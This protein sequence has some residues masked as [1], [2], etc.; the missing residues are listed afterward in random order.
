MRIIRGLGSYPPDARPSVVAL[1]VF[2]GVH[3]AHQ[4]ILDLA[5]ARARE[6]ALSAVACTFDPL[7]L[8]VLRPEQAP[9]P[10]VTLDERLELIAAR[11]VDLTVVIPF[12]REFSRV[13]P[14]AFVADVLL[15]TLRAREVVVG[16]NHT[17]GRGARGNAS[18]LG[19][20][21]ARLGFGLH[22]LPPL[23]VDGS[24]VSSSAVREALR[25]GDVAAARRLLGRPWAL[26]GV[27]VRGAGRGRRLGF[28][29]ANV[30]PD[31]PLPL[32]TGVY[33]GYTRVGPFAGEPG[34]GGAA[35][36]YKTV[37]NVGYRPTFEEGEYWVEAYL[38]D[39]SGDLYDRP[40][41]VSLIERVRE[42]RKF[43]DVS[44]LVTQISADVE[45]AGGIL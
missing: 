36:P 5:T 17:F 21:A 27:V 39:F 41:S 3:L 29:T 26:R 15:G 43:P 18:L 4:R 31:H 23:S 11:S 12:T 33:A 25:G 13:E 1:G 28:P 20:L 19:S 9:V 30:R 45:A 24:P 8:Q 32:A 40:V 7:P 10:I 2:D 14:E 16:F 22:V 6:L 44:A 42:E 38:I 34:G 37:V 35:A